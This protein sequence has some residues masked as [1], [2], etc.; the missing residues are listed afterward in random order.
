MP[1]VV[2]EHGQH[3]V[4]AGLVLVH[5]EDRWVVIAALTGSSGVSLPADDLRAQVAVGDDP[6]VAMP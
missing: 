3:H 5:P 4:G 2:L 1:D 6:V